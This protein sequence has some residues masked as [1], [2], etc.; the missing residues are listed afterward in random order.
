MKEK[1]KKIS[2]ENEG[3]GRAI[4]LDSKLNETKSVSAKVLAGTLKRSRVKVPVIVIDG[5]ATMPIIIS[6]EE[7]GCKVIA[8]KNFA[9]TDT[10]IK[11]MSL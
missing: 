7:V 3:S 10:N 9:S 4:L 1:L 6:A 11:L 5:I 8:A 2:K